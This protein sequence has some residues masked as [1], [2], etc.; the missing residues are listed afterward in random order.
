MA[1]R[2]HLRPTRDHGVQR[3]IGD[4]LARH[5]AAADILGRTQ[6]LRHTYKKTGKLLTMTGTTRHV[7]F[8]EGDDTTY[9]TTGF[10]VDLPQDDAAGYIRDLTPVT[11]EIFD[12]LTSVYRKDAFTLAGTADLRLIQNVQQALAQIAKDGGTAQDFEAAVNA[13]TD[14]AGIARLNAFTLDTAFNTAMQR[15]FSLGRYEQM[16]DG[17]VTSVLPYWQYWTVGDDRVRPESFQIWRRGT[18]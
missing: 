5:L 1:L 10:S 15:A 7:R 16:S 3:R 13:L 6:I 4:V 9:L 2:F 8:D 14:E 18:P 17:A 11:K 12:G